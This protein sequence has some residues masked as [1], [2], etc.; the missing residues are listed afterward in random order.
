V[1]GLQNTDLKW[2]H[3]WIY[4]GPTSPSKFQ[5]VKRETVYIKCGQLSI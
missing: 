4:G 5:G 1:L 3:D 2:R